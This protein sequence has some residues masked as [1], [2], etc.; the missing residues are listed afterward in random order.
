MYKRQVWAHPDE[1]DNPVIL[2]CTPTQRFE[3]AAQFISELR[4]LR[5]GEG[6]TYIFGEVYRNRNFPNG[7]RPE[8]LKNYSSLPLAGTKVRVSS[9]DSSYTVVADQKGHFVLPLER[10]G[11]YRVVADLPM[12]FAR[13]GLDREID[14]EE[15]G[16]SLIHIYDRSTTC[17]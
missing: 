10:G 1:Q 7:V 9:H 17:R 14:L 13:E 11:R 4:E 15:H 12:Y 6:A 3:D 16:L 8:E 5:A 2:D